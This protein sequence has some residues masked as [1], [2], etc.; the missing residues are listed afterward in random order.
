MVSELVSVADRALLQR[1]F[2]KGYLSSEDAQVSYK[3]YLESFRGGDT[4][5][6]DSEEKWDECCKPDAFVARLNERLTGLDMLVRLASGNDGK[7]CL[8]LCN[9][10][11]DVAAREA[12]HSNPVAVALLKKILRDGFLNTESRAHQ[13]GVISLL[14]CKRMAQDIPGRTPL[15]EGEAELFIE[16][17]VDGG[18]L[19]KRRGN[20][21]TSGDQ[22]AI[23]LLP[24]VRSFAEL[25]E[26]EMWRLRRLQI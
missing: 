20:S 8:V 13:D 17:L 11:N 26:M 18:W 14:E 24:G 21:A 6:F 9:T 10:R 5:I 2:S 19:E 1:L 16:D 25:K 3:S 12:T 22:S 15:Q 23:F 4:N 7:T